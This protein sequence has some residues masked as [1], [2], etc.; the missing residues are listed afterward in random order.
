MY[1]PVLVAAL[2]TITGSGTTKTEARPVDAFTAIE[3]GGAWNVE[4]RAGDK[5]TVEVTGDDNIVPLV[6]T[7]VKGGVLVVSGKESVSTKLPLLV[8]IT[9]PSLTSLKLSG[10][11]NANVTDVT[12]TKLELQATGAGK[13]AFK[14]TAEDVTVKS[15]GAGNLSLAGKAKSLEATASGAGN[16]DASAFEV[17]IATIKATGAGNVAV[18][19]T[20]SLDVTASGTGNVVYSGAPK[21]SKKVSGVASVK[22]KNAPAAAPKKESGGGW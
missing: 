8:R 10:A 18:N 11:G 1:I 13:V 9:V 3:S 4:V 19:A 2:A 15:S 12:A 5:A 6:T 20:T 21:L 22:S 16:V 14:G 17:T 7:T